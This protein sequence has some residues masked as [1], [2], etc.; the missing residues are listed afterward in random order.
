[1]STT[2]W[3]AARS[4][5][6]MDPEN[7]STFNPRYSGYK[8]KAHLAKG[9]LSSHGLS[10]IS[11]E[12]VCAPQTDKGVWSIKCDTSVRYKHPGLYQK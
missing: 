9:P 4:D 6:K 3:R 2:Q 7:V 11:N 10:L 12:T 8:S 5:S 1:M